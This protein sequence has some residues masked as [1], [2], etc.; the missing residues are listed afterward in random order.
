[1]ESGFLAVSLLLLL[2]LPLVLFL[3]LLSSRKN[4]QENRY[5]RLEPFLNRFGYQKAKWYQP[6]LEHD[7][8]DYRLIKPDRSFKL[9]VAD[10]WSVQDRR[11]LF[12][13]FWIGVPCYEKFM[14]YTANLEEVAQSILF[15]SHWPMKNLDDWTSLG[16]KVVSHPDHVESL[17]NRL[18]S[19][20][21]RT[22]LQSLLNVK[23]SFYLFGE[24]SSGFHYGVALSE[25]LEQKASIWLSAAEQF[26]DVF[27]EDRRRG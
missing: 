11:P 25:P 26:A 9:R 18:N 12:M 24:V 17:R 8:Y 1:M 14:I 13:I 15:D 5:Q 20:A 2:V 19:P 16:L 27:A 23:A 4:Q 7:L 22:T 6:L 10:E 3:L 21:M